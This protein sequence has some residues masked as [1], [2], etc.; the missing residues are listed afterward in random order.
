[1]NVC[2]YIVPVNEHQ[3][4]HVA[5]TETAGAPNSSSA[6]Y[7]SVKKNPVI[8]CRHHTTNLLSYLCTSE[9]FYQISRH[10][11][12]CITHYVL[13]S[14]IHQ[15]HSYNNRTIYIP[16]NYHLTI[17]LIKYLKKHTILQVIR[18][19]LDHINVNE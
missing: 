16:I 18:T 2:M 19:F 3:V 13:Q 6:M 12:A 14:Y 10:Y 11:T 8:M 17:S 5:T 9:T 15:I 1:M 4:E 7:K